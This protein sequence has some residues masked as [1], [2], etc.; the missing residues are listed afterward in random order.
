MRAALRSLELLPSDPGLRRFAAANLVNTVGSGLYLTGSALFFTRVIGLSSGQVALGLGTATAVGL[1]LMVVCGKLAD[2]VGA[3]P[4]YLGLLLLQAAAM[5]GYVF[6]DGVTGFMV[7]AVISGVAD[8]GI[9]GTVGALIHVVAPPAER[10]TARAQLRTA[11]NVGLGC[12]TLLAGIALSLG[13]PT[14]YRALILGN[15]LLFLVAAALVSRVPARAPLKRGGS[16]GDVPAARTPRPLRDRG[17]LAV[18]AANG[19]LSLHVSTLSFALPLWVVTRTSAPAWS[20]SLLVLVNT[21]LVVL[22]QVRAGRSAATLPA[23]VRQARRAG[24]LLALSC[25]LMFLTA[26]LPGAAVVA[27]LLL[28]AVVFTLGELAQSSSGFYFGFELAPDTAQGA[29]QSVFALGPGIMR[30]LAPGLLSLVVLDHGSAGWLWLG[31]LF[32]V[33]GVLTAACARRAGHRLTADPADPTDPADP[34]D[35]S[36]PVDPADAVR[37]V[38]VPT[39]TGSAA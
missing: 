28:W 14:A 4:V 12:G 20:V 19:L 7:V 36:T 33:A 21:V 38:G 29:Y 26:H 1:A 2:R 25:G 23:A 27:V 6:V 35:A 15:A 24:L 5:T 13:T 34:A 30:S 37:P 11:T 8:R 18:T 17:Y 16:V 31:A 10:L 32:T 22:L 39:A 9:S 3:K